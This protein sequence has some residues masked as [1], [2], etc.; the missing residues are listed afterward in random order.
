MGDFSTALPREG[1]TNEGGNA[2]FINVPSDPLIIGSSEPSAGPVFVVGGGGGNIICAHRLIS[3]L[4]SR[5]RPIDTTIREKDFIFSLH[6]LT[7]VDY[8]TS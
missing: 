6:L 4:N 2:L 3:V 1:V 8:L 5:N 7:S